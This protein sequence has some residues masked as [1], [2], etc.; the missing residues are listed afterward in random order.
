[1]MTGNKY[2]W[3]FIAIGSIFAACRKPYTPNV[4]STSNS[5]LVV[6]GVINSGADSTIIRLSKTVKLTAHDTSTAVSNAVVTIEGESGGKYGLQQPYPADGSYYI[7]G[8]NLDNT[9]KYRLRISTGDNEYVSDYEVVKQNPPIDSVSYKI[10]GNGLHLFASTHDPKNNTK[11]YRW[12]YEEAWRF[13]SKYNSGLIVKEGQ[14]VQRAPNE[15][16]YYCYGAD[17]SGNIVLGSSAKLTQDVIFENPITVVPPTSEKLEIKY[18]I[19]VKQYA[20]TKE[21]YNFWENMRK[22]TEQLGSIFDAQPS[23]LVGNI[24][25]VANPNEPVIGYI[26]VTN[27]QTK[28]IFIANNALP[29]GWSPDVDSYC[30][31]DSALYKNPKTNEDDVDKF[32]FKGGLVPIATILKDA[33]IILGYTASSNDCIDCRVRGRIEAPVFWK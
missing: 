14:I 9:K 16:Y 4:I 33:Y 21:G 22:N 30:L 13:H 19:L 7:V 11:Y 29:S 31:I 28:R 26:S 32:I 25:N 17:K 6:E 8:L 20:L 24:H 10:A 12:A 1:M 15:N 2:I 23:A 27:V 18:S 3:F 5:Y